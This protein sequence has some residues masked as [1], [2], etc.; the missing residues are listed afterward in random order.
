M[1][2]PDETS[3]ALR[4]PS[5]CERLKKVG[6]PLR[7]A[8]HGIAF[9]IALFAVAFMEAGCYPKAAPAPGALSANRVTW[10][11]TRWPGV[12]ASALSAGRDLFLAKCDGCHAYPDL[13]AISEER[14]P[15]IL[16]KMGKKSELSAEERDAVLHYVLASRS[17]PAGQ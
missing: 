2:L 6:L 4:Q 8:A 1:R 16:E 13:T 15:G 5:A 3:A 17:Q 11:S 12:T 10:A 14:W 7:R 9:R